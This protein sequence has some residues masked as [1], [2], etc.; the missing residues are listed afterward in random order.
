MIKHV[1]QL[2]KRKY[3]LKYGEYI[4]EGVRIIRDA[5]ENNIRIKCILFC[6]ELYNTSGGEALLQ[7][8]IGE[9][10]QIYQ[11]TNNVF[12]HISDTKNQ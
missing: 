7:D 12:S 9:N 2:A 10:I 3:R 11:V 6:E 5:L 4:V 8:I 1:K